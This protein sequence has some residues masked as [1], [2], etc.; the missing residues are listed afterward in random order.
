MKAG[1]SIRSARSGNAA[2]PSARPA[3]VCRPCARATSWR[4]VSGACAMSASVSQQI[5]GAC[6]P[7]RSPCCNAHSLPVQPG[8]QRRAGQHGQPGRCAAPAPDPPVPSLLVVHQHDAEIARIILRDQAADRARDHLGL[9]ARGHHGDDRGPGRGLG[10]RHAVV[11]LAQQPEAARR[12]AVQP[13]R[14]RR[15]TGCP[16]SSLDI[17]ASRNQPIA[18]ASAADGAARYSPARAA[19]LAREYT[20]GARHA[21]RIRVSNGSGR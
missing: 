7:R 13:D 18:S 6:P 14:Q 1:T 9:V 16:P 21:Q 20:C 5:V 2:A 4:S 12:A 10:Q 8:G 17:P 3:R 11:A 19:A 15:A